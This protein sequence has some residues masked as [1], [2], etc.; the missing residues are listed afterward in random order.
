MALL[1]GSLLGG[2]ALFFTLTVRR[3]NFVDEYGALGGVVNQLEPIGE[4]FQQL[5]C[6]FI[7]GFADGSGGHVGFCHQVLD[8]VVVHA[9]H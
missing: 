4:G 7:D 5:L 1:F 6:D 8:A 3:Q 2:C 9:L